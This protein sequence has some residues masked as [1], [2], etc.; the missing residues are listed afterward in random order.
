MRT[1]S[2]LSQA[3][4][5]R[6]PADLKVRMV[7]DTLGLLAINLATVLFLFFALRLLVAGIPLLMLRDSLAGK[8]AD[9]GTEEPDQE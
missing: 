9:E 1:Y 3:I 2:V 4:S 6:I 7:L 8:E 5:T